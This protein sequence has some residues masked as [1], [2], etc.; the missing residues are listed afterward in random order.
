MAESSDKKKRPTLFLAEFE[1]PDDIVHAAEQVRDK[2]YKSWD[3]HTPY[4]LHGMDDAMGMEDSKLGWI[5]LAAGLTGLCLAVLMMQ[6]MNGI[7]YPLIIGG[8]PA[9]AV[10]SM[11]P[12]M[13][14]LTVLLASFGAVFGML[15]L[16][17]L[18]RHNHPVFA[19]DRFDN[20]SDDKFFISIEVEDAKFDVEE[21]KTFLESL[22]P[23]H[24]EL[25]EEEE[26]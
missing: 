7:D 14:E 18:P 22:K 3:V 4:P 26:E 21:T 23:S 5:V 19:S 1:K 16:N 25:V 11:V 6:W 2:G 20:C 13:F 15:G 24:L 9:D 8:K 10:P 12:I 17:Q